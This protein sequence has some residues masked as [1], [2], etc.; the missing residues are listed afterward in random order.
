MGIGNSLI[1]PLG[2]IRRSCCRA[3]SVNQRLP[4]RARRDPVRAL[5]AVG[6]GNSLI[7]AAR[8]DPPDLAGAILGEPEVAVGARSDPVWAAACRGDRELADPAARGD[9]TDLVGGNSVNHRL[10]S[11]PVVIPYGKLFAVGI[12]N[13]LNALDRAPAAPCAHARLTADTQTAN[14]PSTDAPLDVRR[15]EP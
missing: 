5:S 14:T 8:C 15:H 10:P 6:I 3:F 7:A 9:A 11:G 2:V 1:A 12:W 13:R 4:S